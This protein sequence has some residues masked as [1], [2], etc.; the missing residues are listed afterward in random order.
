MLGR[1]VTKYFQ[2]LN[3]DLITISRHEIDLSADNVHFLLNDLLSPDHN[4]TLIN[5]AGVIKQRNFKLHEL[6]RVNSLLPHILEDLQIRRNNLNVIHITTDCVYSG[7][8]GKYD[9]YDLH[10]C[11]DEYG[12]SKSL[13]EPKLTTNIRTSIIGEEDTSKYSLLEWVKSNRDGKINGFLNHYWNGVTCLELAKQIE[14]IISDK[15][16][17]QGTKHFFTHTPYS[18]D[19]QPSKYLLLKAI[20]DIYELNLTIDAISTPTAVDRTLSSIYKN[21]FTDKCIKQ[22]LIDLKNFNSKY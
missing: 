14:N 13:G 21:T 16:Y 7:I 11:I 5:C 15:A 8:K 1:Y 17:W 2:Q 9:E 22:Q 10:D 3:Y 12:K 20:D 4:Y 6:I 18:R 19:E